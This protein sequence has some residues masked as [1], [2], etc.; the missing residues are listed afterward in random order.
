MI[1]NFDTTNSQVH[2][3]CDV[4]QSVEFACDGNKRPAVL[5][6]PE[7][8][9]VNQEGRSK[10]K[11]QYLLFVGIVPFDEILYNIMSQLKITKSQRIGQE[12]LDEITFT[13]LLMT[14]KRFFNGG[15]FPRYFYLPPIPSF[16]KD[17]VID[18]QIT[19]TRKITPDLMDHLKQ[20]RI[21][22][23]RSSW[24]EAIPVRFSTYTSRIGVED[25]T[26]DYIDQILKN[27]NLDFSIAK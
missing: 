11:A 7:C 5:L 27:Y 14:L 1:Y 10:P 25:L 26:D 12:T 6:T 18:F 24:K 16:I 20:N 23:I 17:S 2:H 4:F 9:L 8:D 3:Q 19:E 22:R 21:A 15:I 13:D